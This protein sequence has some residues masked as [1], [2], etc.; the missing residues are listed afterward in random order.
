MSGEIL[1]CLSRTLQSTVSIITNQLAKT[2]IALRAQ[3]A[4]LQGNSSHTDVVPAILNLHSGGHTGIA[5]RTVI[6]TV[7]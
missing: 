3:R 2:S 4:L 6:I 1:G 5:E 7:A